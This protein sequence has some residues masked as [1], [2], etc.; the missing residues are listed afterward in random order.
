MSRVVLIGPNRQENLALQYLAASAQAAGHKPHILTCNTRAD[1][2]QVIADTMQLQADVVGLGVQFQHSIDESLLLARSLREAGFRGHLTC[3][4]HVATFCYAELLRDGPFDSIVRHEGEQTLVDLLDALST[5]RTAKDIAGL[6]WREGGGIGMGPKRI[7]IRDIDTLPW[8]QRGAEPYLVAGVPIAFLLSSRGCTDACS[9][10]SISAFSRDAGGPPFRMRDPGAVADE[11]AHLYR[12]LGIRIFFVQDDLF[13]LGSEQAT[14]RRVEAIT[15]ALRARHVTD[16]AFWVKGR[17][18]S[19]TPAVLQAL[20]AMGVLHVFL[21]VE[22]AVDARLAYLGRSHRHADNLRAIALCREHGIVPSFNLMLFDPDCSLDDV[23]HTLSF[24]RETI[25]LPWNMCRTEIYSGTPLLH[26]LKAEG[27]LAG[28]YRSY[29][30]RMRDARAE[31]MFR[32][33]RVALHERAF[34]FDSLLNRLISLSFARQL[35]ERLFPGPESRQ[36]SDEVFALL[37][38]VHEDTLQ[39]LQQALAMAETPGN[40][41]P[42]KTQQEAVAMALA[43]SR[44]DLDWYAHAGQLW[45]Y[46][47]VRG[48][49]LLASGKTAQAQP[50]AH[51]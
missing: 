2:A 15:I 37:R 26:R 40:V 42:E 4:G 47:H 36:L 1:I 9:Y 14:L 13:I 17:P 7:P 33:L 12:D 38:T 35:H 31:L 5:G 11:V 45:E 43:A 22:N 28:D 19:I 25:D 23:A 44:R 16:A 49:H 32:I 10:C 6:V 24:A 3:G 18:D 30:Y 8:P 50:S 46:C 39:I 34:A 27:R 41:D 51:C 48:R 20:R 29:G 21:G